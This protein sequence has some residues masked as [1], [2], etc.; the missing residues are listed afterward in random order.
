MRMADAQVGKVRFA[1]LPPTVT[2]WASV[3]FFESQ[4]GRSRYI[5]GQKKSQVIFAPSRDNLEN[6]SRTPKD[7]LSIPKTG[8]NRLARLPQR[9]EALPLQATDSGSE[10]CRPES[11]PNSCYQRW[12]GTCAYLDHRTV[13]RDLHRGL[14]RPP[15]TSLPADKAS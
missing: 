6:T 4:A 7:P 14:A 13:F 10:S 5:S 8:V 9:A 11:T 2:D 12:K 1:F 3:A 15:V